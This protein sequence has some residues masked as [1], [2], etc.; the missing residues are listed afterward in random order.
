MVA[1]TIYNCS[2]GEGSGRL[3]APGVPFF[4]DMWRVNARWFRCRGERAA[5]PYIG[6]R[7]E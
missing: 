7:T 4:H 6:K 1:A 3:N 2:R 5:G